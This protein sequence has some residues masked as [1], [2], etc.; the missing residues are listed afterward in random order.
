MTPTTM[1][2]QAKSMSASDLKPLFLLDPDTVFLN[3]GSY[4]ACPRPVFE[5]YQRWQR[6]L[7]RQPV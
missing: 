3:H 5:D 1:P 7:E 6:E 4:G 2:S